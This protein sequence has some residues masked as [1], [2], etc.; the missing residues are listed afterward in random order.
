M[1]C[2]K[3]TVSTFGADWT[4][5]EQPWQGMG[6][7]NS[8]VPSIVRDF[9][10]EDFE[11][12]WRMDQ[13]CFAPGIAYS[14]QELRAYIRNRG[15]FTLVAETQTRRNRRDSSWCRADRRGT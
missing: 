4:V 5:P 13:E 7:Y 3:F 1:D 9:K 2:G 11:L 12:L 14:K 10:T 15:S 6:R 8:A